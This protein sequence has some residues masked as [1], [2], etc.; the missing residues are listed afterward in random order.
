MRSIKNVAK[1]LYPSNRWRDF[2]DFNEDALYVPQTCF[3]AP[4]GKTIIPRVYDIARSSSLL[5]A[6][7][8][9]P[10]YL[11]NEYDRRTVVTDVAADGTLS[12]LRYF[13]ENGE[14]GLAVDS[15]GNVYIADGEVQVYDSNGT[16]LRTIHVPERPSTLAIFGDK[17]YI[18]CRKSIYRTDL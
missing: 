3:V 7:P 4:D 12:N 5:E 8:G 13:T 18:T 14:F 17:L 15:K 6:I 10:L 11:V 16:H 9:K 2:H 1:A